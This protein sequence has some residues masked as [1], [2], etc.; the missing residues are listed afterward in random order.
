MISAQTQLSVSLELQTTS[1][2]PVLYLEVKMQ[3]AKEKKVRTEK[4]PCSLG[5]VGRAAHTQTSLS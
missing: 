4:F 2:A 3:K 1:Q 5:Y